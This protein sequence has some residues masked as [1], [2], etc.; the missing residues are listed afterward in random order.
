MN[1]DLLVILELLGSIYSAPEVQTKGG[2][3]LRTLGLLQGLGG[4]VGWEAERGEAL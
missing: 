2:K 4:G 3:L 1:F